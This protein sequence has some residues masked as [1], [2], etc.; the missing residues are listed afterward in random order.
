VLHP[1]ELRV[2]IKLSFVFDT[3]W[4]VSTAL[5]A[6]ALADPVCVNARLVDF[7]LLQ[8]AH[9][10]PSIRIDT[11]RHLVGTATLFLIGSGGVCL[12]HLPQVRNGILT[13]A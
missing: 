13:T 5:S 12:R 8:E 11:L 6:A 1:G 3:G 2:I 9:P 10:V 7:E 4:F